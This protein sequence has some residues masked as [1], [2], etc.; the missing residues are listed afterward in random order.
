MGAGGIL[1]MGMV[2]NPNITSSRAYYLR[3]FNVF[4]GFWMFYNVGKKFENNHH[5]FMMGKM[6]D[7]LPWEVKRAIETQDY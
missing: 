6:F 2:V 4:L 5:T 7:Y 1:L 3:K